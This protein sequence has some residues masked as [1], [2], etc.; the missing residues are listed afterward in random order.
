MTLINNSRGMALEI[1]QRSEASNEAWRNVESHNK[2]KET[3]EILRLSHEINGKTMQ[4]REDPFQFMIEVDWW[5]CR[6][7]NNL[8]S[9]EYFPNIPSFPNFHVPKFGKFGKHASAV[10]T[11]LDN[12][13]VFGHSQ[14]KQG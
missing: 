8:E 2:S 11:P 5:R 14:R 7:L 12:S 10:A 13:H 4:P 9:L 3:R 6:P 1:V